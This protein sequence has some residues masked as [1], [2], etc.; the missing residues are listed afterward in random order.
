MALFRGGLKKCKMQIEYF[1]NGINTVY[2]KN[3]TIFFSK[4]VQNTRFN[5][6]ILEEFVDYNDDLIFLDI[7]LLNEKMLTELLITILK[8]HIIFFK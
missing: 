8:S 6:T 2:L 5:R 7:D 4:R 1:F 3:L